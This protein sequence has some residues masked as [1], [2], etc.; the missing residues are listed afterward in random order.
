[1]IQLI[2]NIYGIEVPG[3]AECFFLDKKHGL[4]FQ[5]RSL[6]RRV[7]LT[8]GSYEAIGLGSDVKDETAAGIV[9]RYCEMYRDYESK[10][11]GL[12]AHCLP[13]SASLHSLI[14]SKGMEPE[15]CFL[16]RKLN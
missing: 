2:E 14:R 15:K 7:K 5:T 13:A 6:M 11:G 4:R 10:L 1:M 8:P 16:I 9:E 12:A 3:N